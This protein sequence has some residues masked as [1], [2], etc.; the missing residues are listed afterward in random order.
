[1]W[2]NARTCPVHAVLGRFCA[3]NLFHPDSEHGRQTN[4]V[5]KALSLPDLAGDDS[6]F[7]RI[8][9]RAV[10]RHLTTGQRGRITAGK[11]FAK[12]IKYD[13]SAQGGR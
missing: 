4:L 13:C 5:Y 2:A 8:R 12:L 10:V 7:K 3:V 6:L 1:V 11:A 9:L